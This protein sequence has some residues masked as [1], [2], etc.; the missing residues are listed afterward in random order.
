MQLNTNKSSLTR[1]SRKPARK[2]AALLLTLFIIFM[3]SSVVLNVLHTEMI[4]FT[5]TRN[6]LDY[7]RALYLANAGLHEACAELEADPAW[8]GT[9]VDGSYPAS[10]TYSATAT[11]A[12]V[13]FVTIT[14]SGVS[15]EVTRTVQATIEL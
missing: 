11:A 15:G 6:Y 4:H 8:L 14:S 7:E 12:G 1:R 13:G 9:A 10:D 2:G 5:A 3:V